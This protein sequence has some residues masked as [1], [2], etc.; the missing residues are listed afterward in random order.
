M[1]Q[2]EII[3]NSNHI[4]DLLKESRVA[5]A[6][7]LLSAQVEQSGKWELKEQLQE[8]SGTYGY[9]LQYLSQGVVD[10]KRFDL[11]ASIVERLYVLN[12]K[13]L[14]ALLESTSYDLFF[15][16]RRD[17]ASLS[18]QQSF[19]D[20]RVACNKYNLLLSVGES[21]RDKNAVLLTLNECERAETTLF[22]KIWSLFP[23]M[24]DEADMLKEA[25]IDETLPVHARALFTAAVFLG[26]MKFYDES[27]L[28]LLMELYCLSHDAEV[29]MRA[30]TAMMIA[31]DQYPHRVRNSEALRHRFDA[32]A[33]M[34][35][36][37][38]DVTTVQRL[39]VRSRNTD[40]IS[41][42]VNEELMP[43]IFK[44]QPD[45]FKKLKDGDTPIDLADI[46][47]NP[48]W[49]QWLDDSG[50]AKKMEELN[51]LQSDGSDVFIATFSHLKSFPFF[52]TLSN[53]F[54]PYHSDHSAVLNT[55][56]DSQKPLR[57]MV[58]TAPFMCNSDKYSL[59]L[60]L[61]RVP[62]AQRDL[63]M[64]Q[65][66]AHHAQIKEMH[67][68][69]LP[70]ERKQHETIINVYV[71]DLY[72]F[73]KLFSRRREFRPVFGSKM[74]F[75]QAPFLAEYLNGKDNVAFIAEFYL[76]NG[77]Y[78]DAISGFNHLLNIE[79]E[80]NP[81]VFQKMGFAYQCSGQI[82]QAIKWYKRYE[83]ADENDLW[84]IRHLAA[85][86]RQAGNLDKAIH[87]YTQAMELAPSNVAGILNLGHTYLEADRLD[88]AM[89]CY[90]KAD[91]MP[92]AKHRAWRPIAWCSF[93]M[94][95]HERSI[96][97][98][99]KV[100]TEDSPT[101]QD[102]L[103]LGHALLCHGEP[104]AAIEQYAAALDALNGDR[105]QFNQM[106]DADVKHLTE[107]GVVRA[108]I[109]LYHDAAMRHN[110]KQ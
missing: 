5:E 32:M 50:I 77:F 47:A 28:A 69:E 46:E 85:C 21:E 58:A 42:R 108:D 16:R 31:I 60:S 90:L 75:L 103:N 3:Q 9:M 37:Q 20:Y 104:Q 96:S 106:F 29:Q 99:N 71:Q 109:S 93:L 87:Y 49:Q 97:Y 102:H 65:L 7:T 30:I 35:C 19:N 68:M 24:G 62:Q 10:P 107:Q 59:C 72:R 88:E 12:D 82:K 14:V 64:S 11:L 91:F 13:S 17:L 4:I 26:L 51:E 67:D 56:P 70:G 41:R 38:H 27:K 79:N 6:I 98:Y 55:L 76:K 53:W 100:L 33:E 2:K 15:T 105:K 83:L 45:I 89:Q 54:L 8:I 110:D 57:D 48:D 92:A 101:A 25:I 40:N 61:D 66:D 80:I 95:N 63:M 43:G 81:V 18:L 22:N 73:F 94:G 78:S 34:A 36:F 86:Y 44:A 52:Q 39:L 23:L 1:D 74:D 84:T